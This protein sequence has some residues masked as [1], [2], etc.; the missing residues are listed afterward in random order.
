MIIDDDDLP[1]PDELSLGEPHNES[2]GAVCGMISEH[3]IDADRLN[4]WLMGLMLVAL[5]HCDASEL[6]ISDALETIPAMSYADM[7]IA[8]FDSMNTLVGVVKRERAKRGRRQKG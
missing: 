1:D 2:Y 8:G 4:R 7:G 6:D 3:I 5:D